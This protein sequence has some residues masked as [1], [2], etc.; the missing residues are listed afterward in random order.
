MICQLTAVFYQEVLC[1]VDKWLYKAFF[2]FKESNWCSIRFRNQCLGVSQI[3]YDNTYCFSAAVILWLLYSRDIQSIPLSSPKMWNQV[4]ETMFNWLIS[5]NESECFI[6]AQFLLHKPVLK[7]YNDTVISIEIFFFVIILFSV[8]CFTE[9]SKLQ[10]RI[11]WT[12]RSQHE[13]KVN[14]F[15]VIT[16]KP[17]RM[18][19]NKWLHHLIHS[20]PQSLST[21]LRK[22]VMRKGRAVRGSKYI[23]PSESKRGSPGSISRPFLETIQKSLWLQ[24]VISFLRCWDKGNLFTG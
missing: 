5:F 22:L 21:W 4:F 8:L 19:S 12:A 16:A 20:R 23:L 11:N 14:G 1:T 18:R 24:L 7:T 9:T 13:G 3:S 6:L 15:F 17:T 10:R 2:A